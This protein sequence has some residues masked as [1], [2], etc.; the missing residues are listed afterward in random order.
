MKY[1]L[2]IVKNVGRH[3]LRTILT[4]L[5]T[6]V[7]VFVVALVW[8][9]LAFLDGLAAERSS[10]FKAICTDRRRI[11]SQMPLSYAQTLAEGAAR[12]PG[13]VRP[14]DYMTW[15]FYGGTLDQGPA[16]R[17]NIVFAVA[18]DP[19]KIR[20]M[21]DDL[22]NIPPEQAAPLD[23]AVAKMLVNR[24]GIILGK[25][26][27]TAMN[28]RIG[29]RF[30]IYSQMYRGI[31]LEFEIVGLFPPG[32][33][34]A[35]AVMN[36]D[37]LNE[38][39]DAYGRKPGNSPHPLADKRLNLVWLKLPNAEAFNRVSAQIMSSPYYTNPAVK[40]ETL[41]SLVNTSLAALRDIIW[42]VRWLLV[43]AALATLSLVIA[44]AI[45]I[46]VRERRVELAVLKVL[47]FR[48]YQILVLVL[49]EA[50]LVGTAAGLASG[51]LTYF[52]VNDVFGGIKF[53][54]GFMNSFYIPAAALWWGASAGT[55][56]ALLGSILPAWSA[57]N[58][59]VAEVFSKVA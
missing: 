14:L 17:E 34:D 44:N 2:L 32:R 55:A 6:M 54:I 38:A 18:V 27:L 35:M 3:P 24:R 31:D 33:W 56:T 43:P 1:L 22:D 5:G 37:Y 47:G 41:A 10:D 45:S 53:P 13:D 12:K 59:K 52:V 39:I 58:V 16:T 46:G 7:L 4:S 25:D 23:A 26:R 21:M 50:V 51:A 20:T 11:P 29:E 15:Q 48:P 19:H 36:A 8:S 40:C 42:G 28:K 49:G 9:V 30:T 57:R